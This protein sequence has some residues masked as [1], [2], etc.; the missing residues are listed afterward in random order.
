MTQDQARATYAVELHSGVGDPEETAAPV[1]GSLPPG[2]YA[3]AAFGP[4]M[5]FRVGAGWT[6]TYENTEELA[7]TIG[8]PQA[9]VWVHFVDVSTET[10]GVLR[11]PLQDESAAMGPLEPFPEDYEA[12]LRTVP[13]LE[14]GP[15]RSV[16]LDGAEGFGVDIDLSRLPVGSCLGRPTKCF[17]PVEQL[18][19]AADPAAPR[20]TATLL[21]VDGTRVLIFTDPDRFQ[22]EVAALLASIRWDV[23]R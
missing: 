14:A 23:E 17:S 11:V 5:T 15:R 20:L 18:I 13:Y 10:A 9:P 3:P 16:V 6:L 21:D 12:W 7:L 22:D 2:R 1:P 19:F 8:D 4:K